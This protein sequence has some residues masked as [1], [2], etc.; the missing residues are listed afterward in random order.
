MSIYFVRVVYVFEMFNELLNDF[1]NGRMGLEKNIIQ[2]EI[3]IYF[4]KTFIENFKEE[5]KT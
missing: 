5:M 2:I 1:I 4:G 3:G